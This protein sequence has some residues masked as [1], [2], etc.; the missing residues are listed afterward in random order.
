MVVAHNSFNLI[1]SRNAEV[2]GINDTRTKVISHSFLP[3][4]TKAQQATSAHNTTTMAE[5]RC[6]RGA[7]LQGSKR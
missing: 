7:T 5:E 2:Q 3:Y 4:P 1:G 6:E